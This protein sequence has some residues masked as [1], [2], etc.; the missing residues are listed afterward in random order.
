LLQDRVGRDLFVRGF[1]GNSRAAELEL[2]L[3]QRDSAM[4]RQNMITACVFL[5]EARALPAFFG[6]PF[7]RRH[8]YRFKPRFFDSVVLTVLEITYYDLSQIAK[9]LARLKA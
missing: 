2:E 3:I 4:M 8:G 7:F 5:R 6:S 9:S 1:G